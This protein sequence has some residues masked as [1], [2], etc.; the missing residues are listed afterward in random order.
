[1][2]AAAPGVG[3]CHVWELR[4]SEPDGQEEGDRRW[5]VPRSLRAAEHVGDVLPAAVGEG[6]DPP[7]E[8]PRHLKRDK[9][10]H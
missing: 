4:T 7:T 2:T 10:Q 9:E 8:L 6:V 3:S 5:S 1:M